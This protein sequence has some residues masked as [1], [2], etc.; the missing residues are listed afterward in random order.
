[1]ALSIAIYLSLIETQGNL[2]KLSIPRNDIWVG[3]QEALDAAEILWQV[4]QTQ[5][6]W[7]HLLGLF[8][9]E[10]V[11]SFKLS[12]GKGIKCSYQVWKASTAGFKGVTLIMQ[13]QRWLQQGKGREKRGF[14]STQ[15]YNTHFHNTMP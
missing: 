2:F 8:M 3:V 10:T 5:E 14:V 12:G 15:H 13:Q 11:L 7:N 4:G 9:S 1:M 6:P